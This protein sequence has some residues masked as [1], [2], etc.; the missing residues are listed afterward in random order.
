LKILQQQQVIKGDY[1]GARKTFALARQA[2]EKGPVT[3]DEMDLM[4]VMGQLSPENAK[5]TRKTID[6]WQDLDKRY[7]ALI[8]VLNFFGK[9]ATKSV[10]LT[11]SNTYFGNCRWVGTSSFSAISPFL[12]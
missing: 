9:S 7:A 12:F 11:G 10:R 3:A 5:A 4:I 1:D 8:G 6:S 2:H